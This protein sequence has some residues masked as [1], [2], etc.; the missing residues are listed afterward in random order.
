A[1]AVLFDKLDRDQVVPQ[2]DRIASG[3]ALLGI[4]WREVADQAGKVGLVRVP[5]L[6]ARSLIEE[7]VGDNAVAADVPRT[8]GAGEVRDRAVEVENLLPVDRAARVR[9]QVPKL[10][11]PARPGARGRVDVAQ[12][13]R[14][15][16]HQILLIRLYKQG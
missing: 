1:L 13:Q 3:V 12:I 11:G 16:R 2:L 9:W 7:G 14:I 6:T 15:F 8:A 5:V 10:G 4:E